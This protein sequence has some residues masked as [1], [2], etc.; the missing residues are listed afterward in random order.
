MP[1]VVIQTGTDRSHAVGLNASIYMQIIGVTQVCVTNHGPVYASVVKSNDSCSTM[2]PTLVTM[3]MNLLN[4]N[5][6]GPVNF[7]PFGTMRNSL[8]DINLISITYI[9]FVYIYFS[10]FLNKAQT[11]LFAM[12]YDLPGYIIILTFINV[13]DSR[14]TLDILKM[15]WVN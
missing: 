6:P 1:G 7:V 15:E 14:L 3:L 10:L 8:F 12:I 4:P 13:I 11:F 2:Q 5:L 9:K